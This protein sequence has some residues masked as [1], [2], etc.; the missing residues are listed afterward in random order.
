MTVATIKA[1]NR[2]VDLEDIWVFPVTWIQALSRQ[3]K[4]PLCLSFPTCKS[5]RFSFLQHFGDQRPE[6]LVLREKRL[7][8]SLRAGTTSS[9]LR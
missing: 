7:V 3:S 8:T 5:G 6:H 4:A 2:N 9:C 1:A